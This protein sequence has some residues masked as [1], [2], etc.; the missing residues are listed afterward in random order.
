VTDNVS[1]KGE[2][3][4]AK[5]NPLNNSSIPSEKSGYSNKDASFSIVRAGMN[6][7]F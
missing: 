5:L 4:Y 6:Y 3:L 1:V 7:K 2:Y